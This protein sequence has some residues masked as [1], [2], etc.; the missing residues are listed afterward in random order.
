VVSLNTI[1]RI[2]IRYRG[3]GIGDWGLG[4]GDWGLERRKERKRGFLLPVVYSIISTCEC[5]SESGSGELASDRLEI[6]PRCLD[7]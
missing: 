3:L 6:L 2:E 5:F 1:W 4:T 7:L